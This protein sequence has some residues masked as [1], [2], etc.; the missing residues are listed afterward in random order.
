MSAAN[1]TLSLGI[2]IGG[3]FTDIVAYE[4][5]SARF[6]GHKVLT[7]PAD[8]SAAVIAGIEALFA[9]RA[10]DCADVGR[11]VHATTLFTNALIERRG[12]PTGLITTRG[13]RDTLELRR[14]HKYELYDLFIELP[15]PLVRRALRLEV[16]ERTAADGSIDTPLDLQ[17]LRTQVAALAT[18]GVESVAVVFLHSYANPTHQLAARDLI[19]REFPQLDVSISSDISPQLREYERTST[20][21]ANAYI[22]P[23]AE[24]YLDRLAAKLNAAGI[25]AP[26][27]MML[28]NGGLTHVAEA[29]RVPIQLLESGP[30]AGAL[31]AA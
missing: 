5:A 20:T 16:T 24:R 21:I 19:R 2:D 28:S 13:F 18:A 14:E 15:R 12:A 23:L 10:L 7:T 11:V 22:K 9:A 6:H 27:F 26:L 29:K 3:T 30:A 17:A 8:P 1:R 25:A 4:H 31:A